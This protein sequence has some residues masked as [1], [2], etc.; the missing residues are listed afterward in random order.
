MKALTERFYQTQSA[1]AET[2]LARA[3][4]H[5]QM[6]RWQH[7]TEEIE[8]P[9]AAGEHDQARARDL[10]MP[11]HRDRCARPAIDRPDTDRPRS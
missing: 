2:D 11:L 6:Q 4:L 9:H 1:P 7:D 3:K 8:R 5:W 10:S